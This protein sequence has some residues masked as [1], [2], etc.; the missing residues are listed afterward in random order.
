MLKI[1]EVEVSLIVNKPTISVAV[2]SEVI[3]DQFNSLSSDSL[4]DIRLSPDYKDVVKF[5]LEAFWT[6]TPNTPDRTKLSPAA[7]AASTAASL[8][9]PASSLIRTSVLNSPIGSRSP[10]ASSI[11]RLSIA[12]EALKEMKEALMTPSKLVEIPRLSPTSPTLLDYGTPLEDLH[13]E[14]GDSENKEKTWD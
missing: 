6:N 9:D 12:N 13:E 14:P 3:L 10:D 8:I 2:I 1:D 7:E 5:M 11:R 4:E